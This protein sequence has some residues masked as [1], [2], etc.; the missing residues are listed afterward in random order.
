MA[1]LIYP[2]LIIGDAD[3]KNTKKV[4]ITD[5]ARMSSVMVL[6]TK[7]SGKSQYVIPMFAKQDFAQKNT[8]MTII[9]SQRDMAYLLYAIA[10]KEKRKVHLLKP[11]INFDILSALLWADSWNYDYINNEVIDYSK[12]IHDKEIV[13]IDMEYYH[14]RNNAV[15]ATSMLLMQLITDMASVQKTGKYRHFVYVDNADRY[16]PFLEL[17]LTDGN[18]YNISTILFFQGRNTF[19]CYG[20]DFTTLI[21]NNVM[22]TILMPNLNWEDTKYYGEKLCPPEEDVKAFTHK[23]MTRKFG[24][25]E[26]DIIGEDYAREIGGGYL[27]TIPDTEMESYKKAAKKYRKSLKQDF[28]EDISYRKA[29]LEEEDN[30][31]NLHRKPVSPIYPSLRPKK[32]N[33]KAGEVET[34]LDN[35]LKKTEQHIEEEPE[36]PEI[37]EK[38]DFSDA[39]QSKEKEAKPEEDTTE[40]KDESDELLNNIDYNGEDTDD[41][42]DKIEK[43]LN[44][45]SG[46]EDTDDVFSEIEG[47]L[48]AD[49]MEFQSM[50]S[51]TEHKAEDMNA[52]EE[53]MKPAKKEEVGSKSGGSGKPLSIDITPH[54]DIRDNKKSFFA[55]PVRAIKAYKNDLR[56]MSQE[57]QFNKT[58]KNMG[59]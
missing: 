20:N 7:S 33:E 29:L 59:I 5:E 2:S 52:A 22:N 3:E 37:I 14:Y 32:E 13:I 58:L 39:P 27:W 28:N 50:E 44:G 19:N 48:S 41:Y 8:G 6:G 36:L 35:V 49:N 25:I 38:N 51:D 56:V 43:E 17:L 30:K 9:V 1:D 21:D 16:L 11:E 45:S 10:K 23:L 24:Q 47:Q 4:K 54:V 34:P 57:D 42:L 12:A 46:S 40:E 55:R 18:S 31:I 15:R 26:Y 53:E